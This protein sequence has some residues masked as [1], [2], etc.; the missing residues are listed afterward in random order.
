M[1]LPLKIFVGD[2]LKVPIKV[3]NGWTS[4]DVELKVVVKKNGKVVMREK[5]DVPRNGYADLEY[6]LSGEAKKIYGQIVEAEEREDVLTVYV[7]QD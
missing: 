5:L 1:N 2:V 6:V 3:A 7:Y 4:E